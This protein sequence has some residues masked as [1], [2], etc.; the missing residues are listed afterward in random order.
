L[1]QGS[2]GAFYGT[3][4]VGGINKAG[5]IFR[6]TTAKAFS[7]LRSLNIAT[8]G[9]TPQG[10]LVIAPKVVLVAN[11]QSGLTTAEDVAKAI[12][13]TGSG[14]PQPD[15]CRNHPPKARLCKHR[16]RRGAYVYA[17]GKFLWC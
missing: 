3:T 17:T 10:G 7:I 4:S 13:L 1:V 15:L 2:D 5:T 16:H 9:G 11:P 12:T 8:D 14:A 6:V